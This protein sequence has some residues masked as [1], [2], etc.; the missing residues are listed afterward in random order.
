MVRRRCK[1]I[2]VL[3]GDADPDRGFVD[4]GDAVRK[5]W[6]D[7]G[8]RISFHGS[9]LL[10]ATRETKPENIPYFALG[11]I[12]YVSDQPIG[13]DKMPCGHILYIKPTVRGDEWAADV[14]AYKRANPAFP[15]QS[16]GDQWFD[17]PQLEAYRALGYL[18][19][20][21]IIKS[22]TPRGRQGPADLPELFE[23]ISEIDPK[24]LQ[25]V[26]RETE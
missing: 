1:W 19:I 17:E 15:H 23:L 7:L 26:Y 25:R 6:I 9:H 21:L 4:L 2:V 24:T 5:V 12:E 22:V 11:T 16:T 20:N 10:Q 18:I 13:G 14:I 3:D 8:A